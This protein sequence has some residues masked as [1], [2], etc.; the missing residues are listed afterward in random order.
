M[1]SW[2]NPDARH[3]DLGWDAYMT[4]GPLA[5]LDAIEEATGEAEVNVIGYCIGGTLLATVLGHMAAIGDHRITS[6]TFFTCIMD[7][8]E[9]G[10][11]TLFVDEEQLAKIERRWTRRAIWT[12]G[13]WRP[14]ST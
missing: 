6:A 4:L 13:P 8:E 11:L 12:P 14:R 5:A 7:F 3:R 9:A 10:E 1:L 2:V